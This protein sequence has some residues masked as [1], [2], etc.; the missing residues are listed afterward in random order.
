MLH[1]PKQGVPDIL[2][3]PNCGCNKH[4]QRDYR[5]RVLYCIDCRIEYFPIINTSDIPFIHHQEL[6]DLLLLWPKVN[7]YVGE[8]KE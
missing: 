7:N 3:C 5:T 4:F 6:I 2:Q 8:E 1:C